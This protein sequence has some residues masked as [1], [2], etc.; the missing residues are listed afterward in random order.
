[1]IRRFWRWLIED[2]RT[3]LLRE[4][5]RLLAAE[6]H[7]L[8]DEQQHDLYARYPYFWWHVNRVAACV[9]MQT[10]EVP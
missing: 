10:E 8:D 6:I 7:K 9:E 1:V 4:S 2:D 3:D 5:A